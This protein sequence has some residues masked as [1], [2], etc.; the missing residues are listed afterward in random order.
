M[1]KVALTKLLMHLQAQ[2]TW[3]SPLLMPFAGQS[4][5]FKLLFLNQTL[6]VLENGYFAMSGN[7]A[8][9]D[10]TVVLTPT[11]LLRLLTKDDA[12][13]V[14]INI[15]GNT[16]LA[17]TMANI[18]SNMRWD[19]ADDLSKVIGDIPAEKISQ[20]TQSSIQTIKQSTQN[21]SDMVTEY[22]HEE[23]MVIAKGRHV[24]QFNREVDRLQEDVARL[25][26]RITKLQHRMAK[27]STQPNT[28]K[29]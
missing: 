14:N 7:T 29:F 15:T 5:T 27:Q 25:E 24:D 17:S 3:A 19:Y 10:A 13:K 16:Q 1:F 12:A 26:K 2:N 11:T 18:F 4:I 23:S 28:A 6:V 9:S 21:A 8:V 22:L 20:A